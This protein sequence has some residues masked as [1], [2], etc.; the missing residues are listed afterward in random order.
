[1]AGKDMIF[2]HNYGERLFLG[3]RNIDFTDLKKTKGVDVKWI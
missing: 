1:M 3:G 2:M